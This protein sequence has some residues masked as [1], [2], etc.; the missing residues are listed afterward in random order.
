MDR[1]KV[2]I[3]LGPAGKGRRLGTEVIDEKVYDRQKVKKETKEIIEQELEEKM[4][5]KAYS[6]GRIEI[7]GKVY[8]SDVIVYPDKVVSNWW[9]KTGH[10]L[11]VEDIKDVLHSKPQVLIVGTGYSGLMK[12][13]PETE[14]KLRQEGIKLIVQQ[15][16]E[17]CKTFNELVE[18]TFAVAALHLTC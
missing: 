3:R 4:K 18:T 7:D 6:F 12:V 15:T 13:L 9:R 8:Q 16:K 14:E 11:C 5:I 1:K 2:K 17:A 10:Q